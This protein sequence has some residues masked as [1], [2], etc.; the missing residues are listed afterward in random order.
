[1]N[2]HFFSTGNLDRYNNQNGRVLANKLNIAVFN[3]FT[4]ILINYFN[5]RPNRE[6]SFLSKLLK[7]SPDFKSPAIRPGKE[8]T[9]YSL[10]PIFPLT[11]L[12]AAPRR[13]AKRRKRN[14]S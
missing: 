1:M 4:C 11:K 8:E 2:Q 6:M 5:I 13:K 3:Y 10:F 12:D 7:K 9:K 14:V